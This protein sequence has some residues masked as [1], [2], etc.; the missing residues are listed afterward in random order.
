[1]KESKNSNKF[2]PM[3]THYWQIKNQYPDTI[4]LYR[5][6]DFYEMFFDDAKKASKILDLTLTGR[7][8][9][10]DERAPMCGVPYHAVE[11]YI[12]RLLSAGE[13]VAICEQ[14]TNPGDQKGMVKRD[15]IRVITPGT[16]TIEE[17]LDNT[18]NHY[19][20]AIIR[21]KEKVKYAVA[22]LD[23]VTG[24]F[25]VK[26]FHDATLSDVEDFLLNIMPSEIISTSEI[27]AE[28]KRLNSVICERLVRFTPFY[29][30]NFDYSN[31]K[32]RLL[33][34]F[35]AFGLEALGL[36]GEDLGV[37]AL[38][39]LLEYVVSTQKQ[40]LTHISVPT[41]EADDEEMYIDFNTRKNLE[42]TETLSD[43]KRN[44][45]L[46]WVIDRTK[47]GMGD[48]KSVV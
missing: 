20:V 12:S 43:G 1:M 42:L 41:I 9:G 30:Y 8:C 5:L 26:K 4:V 11:N 2:S 13:K 19:L 17:M 35:S 31:A 40:S 3:M 7:D 48:R 34:E 36:Y 18:V 21:D 10:Q 22:M 45:S 39:G 46:L 24:E 28:G 25:K 37:C 32:N 29:D 33:K 16:N 6:G 38:G 15:V 44:G 23:I 14:L 27:C 47:T